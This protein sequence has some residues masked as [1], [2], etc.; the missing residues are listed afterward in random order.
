MVIKHKTASEREQYFTL[1]ELLVVIAI[2]AILAAML[3][4]VLSR[5]KTMAKLIDCT[6]RIRQLGPATMMYSDDSD[7]WWPIQ[8]PNVNGP[9]DART[10]CARYIGMYNQLYNYKQWNSGNALA[11]P[12]VC[13]AS[14]SIGREPL[15]TFW[16]P[17]S[18]GRYFDALARL[19]GSNILSC[20]TI[21]P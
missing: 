17:D 18:R 9:L 8:Y 14:Y 1:I 11:N 4:P 15:V 13:P 5:A 19:G 7:A 21:N 3:L 16:V 20:Y 6:S 2:I 10:V 12:L